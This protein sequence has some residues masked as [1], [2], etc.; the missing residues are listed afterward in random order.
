MKII[1]IY[2]LFIISNLFEITFQKIESNN[3][4]DNNDSTNYKSNFFIISILIL[5][6]TLYFFYKRKLNH[7]NFEKYI[8]QE[9]SKP[10]IYINNHDEIRGD[11]SKYISQKR[12]KQKTPNNLVDEKGKIIFGTFEKE[13]E[14]MDLLKAKGPTRLPNMFYDKRTKSTYCWETKVPSSQVQISK[15]LINGSIAEL[16]TKNSYIKFIN[17]FEKVECLMYGKHI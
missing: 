14:N 2:L 13:F 1:L 5:I 4:I 6:S 8:E 15:N 9:N 17:N 16:K 7:K 11:Y 10:I 3:K 12:R